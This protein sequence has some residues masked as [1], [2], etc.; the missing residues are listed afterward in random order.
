MAVSGNMATGNTVSSWAE[1]Q[2]KKLME[3]K[4]M[5][6]LRY[7]RVGDMQRAA[8]MAQHMSPDTLAGL[9]VGQLLGDAVGR[10]MNGGGGKRDGDKNK[11]N[12]SAS[13]SYISGQTE[14]APKPL[15][16]GS[17]GNIAYSPELAQADYMMTGNP[18]NFGIGGTPSKELENEI[19]QKGIENTLKNRAPFDNQVAA[20]DVLRS[21]GLLG[22]GFSPADY[23]LRKKIDD[24]LSGGWR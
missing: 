1:D 11:N 18:G 10:W 2:L 24:M 3:Q 19:L 9:F 6:E 15:L 14:Q 7:Q 16:G 5:E 8:T 21:V 13:D 12:V 17:Y 22:D 20:N 23:S 4:Q